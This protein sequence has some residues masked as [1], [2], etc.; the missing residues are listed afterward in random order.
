MKL[1]KFLQ[2]KQLLK[3]KEE[4]KFI[5]ESATSKK[6]PKARYGLTSEEA[7]EQDEEVNINSKELMEL[8]SEDFDYEIKD[9][10][11]NRF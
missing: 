1:V 3:Y 5:D 4:I 6:Q 2:E 8:V 9:K 11:L 7:I 10:D